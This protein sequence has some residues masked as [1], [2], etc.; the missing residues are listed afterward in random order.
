MTQSD[1]MRRDV[2][3]ITPASH[4]DVLH[5]AGNDL[6][7]EYRFEPGTPQDG[8]TLVVPLPLLPALDA[9]VLSSLIPGWRV[10]KITELLR[11]LPKQVRKAFVPVP[12]HAARAAAELDPN[13]PFDVEMAEWITRTGGTPMTAE[14]VAALPAPDH[15]RFNVRVVDLH[16]A[17]LA[18]G[19]DITALR[20]SVRRHDAEPAGRPAVHRRWDFGELPTEQAVERRGL[21]F[22][23]YPTL[24]D[25]GDGVE[26]AEAASPADAQESLRSAVLRLALLTLAEQHKYARKRLAEQRELVLLGQGVNAGRPL[27][28]ALAQK[29]FEEC[30]LGEPVTLPRSAAQFNALLDAR[31]ANFGEVVDRVMA[32]ATEVLKELRAVRQKLAPLGSPAFLPLQRDVGAQLA[33]LVP[34]DFPNGVAAA[35]WPHLPRYLKALSRRLDKAPGN[36]KRDTELMASVA[37]AM[38]A[39]EQLSAQAHRGVALSELARLQW[40]IEELRVSLFA[41]DLR[42]V[43]PVSEKRVAEQ[44]ERA[45]AESARAA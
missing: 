44:V 25:R 5:V 8:I 10:E 35:L 45:R 15:L 23:V 32:H 31:R 9:S 21:R 33:A 38:R 41:Q 39:F 20:R 4:P 37:P 7:L 26:L 16:G 6:P 36:Q 2:Q 19:R 43:L 34:D 27:A 12:E 42:T 17:T 18:E 3:E 13:R 11:S 29:A 1:L 28:D 30:F 22:V 14:E 24:R 40:M